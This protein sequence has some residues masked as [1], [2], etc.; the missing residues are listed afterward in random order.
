MVVS[1]AFAV[2]AKML[3]SM[4][5][6]ADLSFFDHLLGAFSGGTRAFVAALFIYGVVTLFSSFIPS[7]WM[8]ESLT[9]RAAAVAWPPV[10]RLLT[11]RGWLRAGDLAPQAP[12][13]QIN[14]LNQINQQINALS[15]LN[16]LASLDT[17]P[18]VPAI[19]EGYAVPVP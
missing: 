14:Q 5:K 11:E 16:S 7:A 19:P 4:I 8:Q 13:L 3:R 1:L 18:G 6:A 10:F 2:A 9:M 12:S 15:T 17:F